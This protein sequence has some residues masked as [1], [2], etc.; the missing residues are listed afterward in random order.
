MWD[1]GDTASSGH[2]CGQGGEVTWSAEWECHSCG[3][4]GDGQFDD[5]TT[6]Y[7]DH[8]CA[9]EDEGAAA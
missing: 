6:T 7:S 4:S 2:D 3:D 1:D 9:D 5:D 8:E